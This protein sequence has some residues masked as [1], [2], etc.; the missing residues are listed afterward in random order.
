M[1]ITMPGDKDLLDELEEL[2]EI[3]EGKSEE[4]MKRELEEIE[5]IAGITEET[6]EEEP[7]TAEEHEETKEKTAAIEPVKEKEEN[8]EKPKKENVVKPHPERVIKKYGALK[9]ASGILIVIGTIIYILAF[10]LRLYAGWRL[11]NYPPSALVAAAG[12]ILMIIGG[13]FYLR[14]KVR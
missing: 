11:I 3:V 4:E 10:Y 7:E 2:S 6:K 1:A 8:V 5:E 12:V 9:Y 13:D 14:A